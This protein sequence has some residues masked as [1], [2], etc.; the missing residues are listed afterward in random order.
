MTNHTRRRIVG[1]TGVLATAGPLFWI[2][3][4]RGLDA[5]ALDEARQVMLAAGVSREAVAAVARAGPDEGV[6]MYLRGSI[7]TLTRRG[8]RELV[9]PERLALLHAALGDGVG[10]LRCLREAAET[11]SPMLLGGWGFRD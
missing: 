2:Q 3:R 6:R 4:A 11:R 1:T 10:A 8:D 9:A 5:E 7:A